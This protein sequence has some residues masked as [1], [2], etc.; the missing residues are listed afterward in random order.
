MPPDDLVES[1]FK[2]GDIEF[3]A[4]IK[5]EY[6]MKWRLADTSDFTKPLKK[7]PAFLIVREGWFSAVRQVRNRFG[8]RCATLT[9]LIDQLRQLRDRG[10]G[11]H[12]LQRHLNLEDIPY[13]RNNADRQQGVAA[14][15][16]KVVMNSDPWTT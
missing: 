4:P 14:K 11:K 15:F 8:M 7:Q 9:L 2:Q 16:E 3:A 5:A 12:G 6:G 13:S 10:P 1:S